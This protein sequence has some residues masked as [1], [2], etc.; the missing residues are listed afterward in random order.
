MGLILRV[1]PDESPLD[2]LLRQARRYGLEAEAAASY[3]EHRAKGDDDDLAAWRAA[4]DWDILD[5]STSEETG[6]TADDRQN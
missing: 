6:S 2:A 4:Y 5:I 3:E 1:E